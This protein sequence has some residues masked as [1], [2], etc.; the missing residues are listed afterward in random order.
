MWD[1]ITQIEDLQGAFM[2]DNGGF[3]ADRQPAGRYAFKR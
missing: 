1:H 2:R 3:L